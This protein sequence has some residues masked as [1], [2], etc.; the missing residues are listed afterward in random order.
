MKKRNKNAACHQQLEESPVTTPTERSP[1]MDTTVQEKPA[2][3][4]HSLI[5]EIK[6]GVANIQCSDEWKR[7][8]DMSARFWR[9]SFH[10]QMLI[11]IQR[12]NATLVAGFNAWK[13]M[14]RYVKQ[15]EHGIRILA[16]MLVKVK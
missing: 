13:E 4:V 11:A 5:E 12:P 9:Y 2:D 16:P 7:F 1:T 3:K 10:N 8:L 15:G 14:G 6:A